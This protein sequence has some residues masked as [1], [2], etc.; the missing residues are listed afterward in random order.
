MYG[1]N[2]CGEREHARDGGGKETEAVFE[3]GWK[4]ED[5]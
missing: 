4:A 3:G 1:E 5:F 2:V